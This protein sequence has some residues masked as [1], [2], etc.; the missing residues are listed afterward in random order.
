[1]R[2]GAPHRLDHATLSVIP[3]NI[4]SVIPNNIQSVIPNNIQD[5]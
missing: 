1:M 3:N 5:T 2:A 4:Q